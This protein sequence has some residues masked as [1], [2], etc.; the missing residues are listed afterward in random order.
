MSELPQREIIREHEFEEQLSALIPDLRT[1]DDFVAAAET[2]LA[3]DPTLGA[4]VTSDATIWV[5]SMPPI[6]ENSIVLYYQFDE[7]TVT[8]LYI[9]ALDK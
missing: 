3:Y 9:V 8:L 6:E 2:V 4:P 5:L 1:A 7:S